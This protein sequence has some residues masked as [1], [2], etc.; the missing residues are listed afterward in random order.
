M[1]FKPV[2][3]LSSDLNIF[4]P[5]II[6]SGCLDGDYVEFKPI[7]A[8]G[9]GPITFYVTPSNEKYIALDRTLLKINFKVT[10]A[11]GVAI[12]AASTV[13]LANYTLNTLFSNIKIELNSTQIGN[14]SHLNHYRS[15]IEALLSFSDV[16]KKSHLTSALFYQDEAGKMAD[17]TS[18]PLKKR[19]TFIKEGKV[20][21]LMG[22]IHTDLCSQQKLLLNETAVRITLARN[23]PKIVLMCADTLSP[24]IT[25]TD[26]SLFIR[27]ITINSSVLLAHAK[28]LQT[29]TAK[30][31]I[32]KV[33]V[34]SYSI[35]SGTTTTHIENICPGLLPARLIIGLVKS[36]SVHGTYSEN[37]FNFDKFDLNMLSVSID[38]RSIGGKPLAPNFSTGSYM[39]CFTQLYTGSGVF[40]TDDG[41]SIDRE[42][43]GKGGFVL[44]AFDFTPTL[45]AS[46]EN[47]ALQTEANVRINLGFGT[48]TPNVLS[49]ICYTEGRA[50]L[51]GDKHRQYAL[52]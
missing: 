40:L 41:A 22:R 7:Q 14:T 42:I 37:P 15:Y 32:K 39:E 27:K 44:Y 17:L 25:I 10:D 19:A 47:W 50:V 24:K 45:S 21:E 1:A 28:M 35:A 33:D 4:A 23:D 20:V 3:G 11:A 29:H 18:E 31:P 48:A 5:P 8:L 26:A 52:V 46:D 16:S 36:T 43:Y 34:V 38:G 51:Q 12:A 9:D 6:E 49:L 2:E 30:Y 13:S